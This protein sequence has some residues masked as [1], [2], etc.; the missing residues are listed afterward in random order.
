TLPPF[1]QNSF[2]GCDSIKN[3][4]VS[5]T[6]NGPFDL[7]LQNITWSSTDMKPAQYSVTLSSQPP[8][9][10]VKNAVKIF[11]HQVDTFQHG[12]VVLTFT[13]CANNI[14][15]DTLCFTAHPPLPDRTAPIFYSD[16]SDCHSRCK[17]ITITDS[18][19]SA[20]SIDRGI[21]SI[22]VFSS[23]NMT[24]AGLPSGGV[25]P[26]DTP[27]TSLTACVTDSMQNGQ[28]I[29]RANDTTHNFAFDTIAYC[30]TP[31]T[32]APIITA[33]ALDAATGSWRVHISEIRPWDRGIDSVWIESANNVTT[34]PSPIPTLA[35][36]QTYDLD[37]HILDTSFCASAMVFARDCA[38][39]SA[40]PFPVSYTKGTK[41]VITASKLI[42]CSVTDSAVLDA[43]PN[44][45]GYRWSTKDTTRII[46]VHAAGNYFVTVQEG[47]GCPATSDPVTVALS[48]VSPA[49]VPGGPFTLCAP[50]SV[51]LDA[52]SGYAT[53]QWSK[54]GIA[55]PGATSETIEASASGSYTAAVTNAAG[56]AGTSTP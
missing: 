35:C 21:D 56:C 55:I 36:V 47:D 23:T 45:T 1:F 53:Y 43:G 6:D 50:D 4:T 11:V 49:I 31:D 24:L 2:S 16:N 34:V 26:S 10:C 32:L 52:G 29:L 3:D 8:F 7:G 19:K 42:L 37:V 14:S 13:D 5:V 17:T 46:V 22:V 15:Y 20:T 39:D 40:G 25:Y 28:I 44:Y 30:T 51:K 27:V 18:A 54:D 12:H 9:S 38:G 48:P 33:S 41:P